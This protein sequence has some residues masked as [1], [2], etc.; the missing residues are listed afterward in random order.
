MDFETR[1]YSTFTK[2]RTN[3]PNLMSELKSEKRRCDMF[4]YG[5]KL[6]LNLERSTFWQERVSW[7]GCRVEFCRNRI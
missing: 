4:F 2:I 6:P 5:F 1:F 3:H 7:V